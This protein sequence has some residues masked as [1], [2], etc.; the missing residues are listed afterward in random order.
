MNILVTGC[1]G[2]IGFH[3]CLKLL[4]NK[5][6]NL[7]GID[8]LNKYY[9]VNLKLQRLASLKK[10]SKAKQFKFSKI[11]IVNKKKLFTFF[12]KNKIDYVIHL[13][14]QAGVRYS[15]K[16]PEKYFESNL[17]GF[18]NILECSRK[19]NI[20]HLIF[21]S[22]SS[23]YGN[24]KKFPLTE[25]LNTDKPISFYAATKKSN[26]VMA[27][28]Y[29]YIYNLPSTGLRFFTVYGPNG[30]PDMSLFK[31]VKSIKS[32]KEISVFNN[33]KHTRDFTFI[34]D[35]VD[36]IN[37]LILKPPINNNPPFNI[38]NIANGN[39][40]KLIDFIKLI[41]KNLN[42]KSVKKKLPMQMGDVPK[43]HGDIR[44]IKKLINYNPKTSIEKGINIF[45]KWYLNK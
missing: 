36:A 33:G 8:N 15:I 19:N 31:F 39:P 30:R 7:L 28:S 11:D 13:A 9:D 23:V 10:K 16:Y 24:S 3:V 27:Y 22:T 44:K 5:K 21:A 6:I 45:V 14:A 18:F 1:A 41:E 32:K 17:K 42:M 2:F 37:K 29:S 20:K 26:E 4:E 43:T 12:K 25:D 35:V 34:N 40:R 38:L